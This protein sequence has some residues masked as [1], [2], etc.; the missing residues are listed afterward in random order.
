MSFANSLINCDCIKIYI[1]INE[2]I[3]SEVYERL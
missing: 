3:V 1:V 2:I